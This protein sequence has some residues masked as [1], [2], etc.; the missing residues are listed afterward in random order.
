MLKIFFLISVML[1][2]AGFFAGCDGSS[3][4]YSFY[5]T[6]VST[7]GDVGGLTVDYIELYNSTDE[8]IDLTG[9]NFGDSEDPEDHYA[10]TSSV[11]VNEWSTTTD[12][13]GVVTGEWVSGDTEIAGSSAVI[14][15]GGYLIIL[16]SNDFEIDDAVSKTT[17]P[18][19][20]IDG[21][22][23]VTVGAGFSGE[24]YL[25]IPAGLKGSKAEGVYMYKTDGITQ[26][27]GIFTYE[28]DEQEDDKVFL[29]DGSSWSQG[30]PSPGAANE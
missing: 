13:E 24:T 16:F 30:D 12:S 26:A 5:L 2:T 20:W 3:N 17:L 18:E 10:V 22:E 21:D 15:A 29:Y 19:S 23:I 11:T 8:D 1:A 28:A 14:P 25:T 27:T 4:T 9:Y 6:E 7:S